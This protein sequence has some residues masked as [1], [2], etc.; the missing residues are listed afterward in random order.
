MRS[1][2]NQINATR[3]IGDVCCQ[4]AAA[5]SATERD[6]E[7]GAGREASDVEFPTT[8][9]VKLY[10]GYPPD[11]QTPPPP[12]QPSFSATW[13]AQDSYREVRLHW[14]H[15]GAE[16]LGQ[17]LEVATSVGMLKTNHVRLLCVILCTMHAPFRVA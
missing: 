15:R 1:S 6:A 16:G 10:R 12:P 8:P 14:G 11:V 5:A 13:T 2:K 9:G 3:R 17:T 7:L 4:Q